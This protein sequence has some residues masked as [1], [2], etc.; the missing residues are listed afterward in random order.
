MLI[1]QPVR[2]S[3][4]GHR[5][6]CQLGFLALGSRGLDLVRCKT[7][8]IYVMTGEVDFCF[9]GEGFVDFVKRL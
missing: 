4:G 6:Q 1:E 5:V 2:P 7:S 8:D 9:D 3:V